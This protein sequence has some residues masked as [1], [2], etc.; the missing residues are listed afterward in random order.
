MAAISYS[1]EWMLRVFIITL[2]GL[3][4][5]LIIYT[6]QECFQYEDKLQTEGRWMISL[7]MFELMVTL[8][9]SIWR[10]QFN[11][12]ELNDDEVGFKRANSSYSIE[13]SEKTRQSQPRDFTFRRKY[14]STTKSN[15]EGGNARRS[16]G[17]SESSTTPPFGTVKSD[18]KAGSLMGKTDINSVR[19]T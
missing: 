18:R 5:Y 8:M 13:K 7:A 6:S 12:F 3:Q 2:V 19:E 17:L 4:F 1:I 15:N 9:F 14:S 11:P 16:N 10:L